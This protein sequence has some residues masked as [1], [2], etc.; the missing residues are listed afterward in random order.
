ML[1]SLPCFSFLPDEEKRS[2]RKFAKYNFHL[3]TKSNFSSCPT[4]NSPTS[5]QAYPTTLAVSVSLSVATSLTLN[6]ATI[7]TLTSLKRFIVFPVSLAI[8]SS[9][10]GA[11]AEK[12][13]FSKLRSLSERIRQTNM[14]FKNIRK[15]RGDAETPLESLVGAAVFSDCKGRFRCAYNHTFNKTRTKQKVKISRIVTNHNADLNIKE[16]PI[17]HIS[18]EREK[19]LKDKWVYNQS[20][21]NL[22]THHI[23]VLLK[24][25]AFTPTP[26]KPPT[27]LLLLKPEPA[28]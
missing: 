21:K 24:G 19:E 12:K 7:F 9:V 4:Y 23:N 25:L 16:K 26:H 13:S 28:N 14:T 3:F 8:S 10:K 2:V 1:L 20:A 6:G 11:R 17:M 15:D 5:T 18:R 22:S 27:P